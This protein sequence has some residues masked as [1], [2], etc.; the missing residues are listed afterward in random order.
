M[1]P[2]W[3]ATEAAAAAGGLSPVDWTATGVSIDTRSLVAGDLFVALHGPDRDGHDFVGAAFERGAAA[4][5]VDR[6]LPDLPPMAPVL[7]VADT[8]SGLSALGAA[9]RNRSGARIIAVTGSVGKTGTKEALRLALAACGPTFASAGGLNNHWGV[10]LSLARMPPVAGYGIFELGMNHPGEIAVLTRQVRPHVAVVTTVEPA[11]L[12]FFASVEAIADAKGEIFLGLEPGG[13]AV[14]NC[15]N[16][17]YRRLA[18]A[19]ERA[20]AGAIIGF[21]ADPSAKVRLVDCILDQDG[22]W[23]EAALADTVLRFRLQVPGRHWVMNALAVLAGVRAV[24]A[25]VERA[26]AALA[27]LEA[28]PGRGRRQRV[29]WQ[30]GALTLIDESYNASP[31]SMRAAIAVLGATAPAR[32]AKRVAVLGDMLELGETAEDF[33]RELAESLLVAKV[34]RVFLIGTI[35]R[36][37]HEALPGF[38]RGGL[39]RTADEAIPL[40]LTSLLPGDVVTVKGSRAMALDRIV[41]ELRARG[42]RLEA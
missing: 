14:L 36:A 2:L 22:S 5:M 25:D 33:H 4:A 40:L 3:T 26:A 24:G 31:A 10:P 35:I 27:E 38:I 37:L 28:M 34:D 13:V 9:A 11:H 32:G 30:G 41:D 12:G 6:P 1:K 15:D 18:A 8:L 29:A 42:K 19:A 17:H 23:V 16:P 7:R 20:G 39:C 21:G